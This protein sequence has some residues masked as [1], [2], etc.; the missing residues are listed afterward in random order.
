MQRQGD[1]IVREGAGRFLAAAIP[2]AQLLLMP[3]DDHWWW[4]GDAEA[5]L[6]ATQQ[7][8]DRHAAGSAA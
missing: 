4:H 6:R 8:I 7:F 3:G 5:V 1:L 2:G